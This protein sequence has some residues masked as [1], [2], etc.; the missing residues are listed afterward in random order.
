MLSNETRELI[1]S[2][3]CCV[4]CVCMIYLVYAVLFK[5]VKYNVE[6]DDTQLKSIKSPGYNFVVSSN[7]KLNTRIGKRDIGRK[8]C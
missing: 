6:Y 5:L 4:I 8:Y 3:L 1:V 7:K 2:S